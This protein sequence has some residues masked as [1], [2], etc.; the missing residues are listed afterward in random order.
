[1]DEKEFLSTLNDHQRE[2]VLHRG[3]PLLILAGAGSG[4]TR[5]ITMK[6]AHLIEYCGIDPRSILAVTFTNKA[7]R[8]M[9]ERV[10][11]FSPQGRHVMIR[12]FHSFGAWMLRR[13]AALAGLTSSFTIYD[14]DDALTL[15]H[16]VC[17]EYKRQDLRQYTRW[18]SRAKDYALGPSDDLS[19]ISQDPKLPEMYRKYAD[20]SDSIGN[21]DFGDLILKPLRLLESSAEVR[22][23]MHQRFRVILVDEYQ[24]SNVAQYLL[25]NALYSEGCE[26]CVVGD[27]DQSIYRFRG[28][29][30]QNILSFQAQFKD[31]KV[32][33][34]EENYRSTG[35]ILLAASEVVSHNS[36]RLGKT[37]WT[38]NE[39]G[40]KP[41]LIMLDSHDDEA[42][43]C[44]N[45]V[46]DGPFGDYALLYRTNAQS[47][48]FESCFLKKNIP[49]RIVG[50][51][52]F[53]ERE[54][55]KDVLA[56]LA[57]VLNPRDEVAFRRMV[58]KPRRGIGDGGLDTILGYAPQA[59][60]DLR[61]ACDMATPH[62]SSRAA[63]GAKEFA[64]VLARAETSLDEEPLSQIILRLATDAGLV[65]Y[66]TEQDEIGSTQR[67]MNIEELINAAEKYPLGR[68]GLIS[69]L[70]DI[71]L[72]RSKMTDEEDGGDFV[73]LIT[74]HNTKGL[75]FEKVVITGLEQEL[76]PGYRSQ[77]DAD[78]LEEE[79]RI[80]YVSITRAKKELYLTS[81][82]RRLIWG[83][84][85]EMV[86]SI[87]LNELP[88]DAVEFVDTVGE[89]LM[90]GGNEEFPPGTGV[91]HDDYG[92][93]QVIKS[94]N[95]GKYD[96]VLV[97]FQTGKTAQFIPAY[98]PLEK[99]SLDY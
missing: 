86:P 7:A 18:I 94:W 89:T 13:N 27:D 30:V 50:A 83:R 1:M 35:N 38:R 11:G 68:D 73:T 5:V 79:R 97:R 31:T 48:A 66:Y 28:A 32:I 6:I 98:A 95:N 47:L 44:A 12:T 9:A 26:L 15:L 92:I 67:V 57:L 29:E 10:S 93:G 4:K 19:K 36:G 80:F 85:Q 90:A 25:L 39:E 24:D 51:L 20:K 61:A 99:V 75:E 40:M 69:F 53:Y 43:Y 23:R 37:L 63:R 14:D 46:K 72:D 49:Y 87:F 91:Y 16:S 96:V 77:G 42:E 17:P 55:I 8:E 70:E 33:R 54:E 3:S 34:L 52:R 71:E 60:G 56:L 74:M 62:L 45:L 21:A 84:R 76:F 59:N 2:A 88:K 41:R 81:C 82:R 65:R 58:N 78:A 64:S 22:N